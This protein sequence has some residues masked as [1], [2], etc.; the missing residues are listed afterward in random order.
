M[1]L[2]AHLSSAACSRYNTRTFDRLCLLS[3]SQNLFLRLIV[4]YLL[5]QRLNIVVSESVG[6]KLTAEQLQLM[7]RRLNSTLSQIEL[8]AAV[9]GMDANGNGVVTDQELCAWFIKT[10]MEIALLDSAS[11]P[12]AVPRKKDVK[13]T[14]EVGVAKKTKQGTKSKKSAALLQKSDGG[15][16]DALDSST[17]DADTSGVE[18]E[19]EGGV[20]DSSVFSLQEGFSSGH[21]DSGAAI[22]AQDVASSEE[23]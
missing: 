9:T 23:S 21:V 2:G 15:G 20:Q 14:K 17:C 1:A 12:D 22:V 7:V 19:Q 18:A 3:S 4:P 16:G 5:Q 13:K 10:E 11:F 8:E 6:S